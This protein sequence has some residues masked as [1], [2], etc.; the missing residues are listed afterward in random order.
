MF[1][2]T[3]MG[4]A[5]NVIFLEKL[6]SV[7]FS[8]FDLFGFNQHQITSL[9]RTIYNNLSMHYAT[10]ITNYQEIDPHYVTEDRLVNVNASLFLPVHVH[11]YLM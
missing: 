7:S 4:T 5:D 8:Y 9:P 2:K 6:D 11:F 1:N 10:L 3:L